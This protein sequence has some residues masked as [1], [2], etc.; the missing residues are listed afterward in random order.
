MNIFLLLDNAKMALD[1]NENDKAK[2]YIDQAI[3]QLEKIV[4]ASNLLSEGI[5]GK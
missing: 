2:E 5:E 1:R 4:D 3:E